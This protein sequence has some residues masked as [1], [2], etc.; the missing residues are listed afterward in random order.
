MRA[1]DLAANTDLTA[2]TG[3]I[4]VDTIAPESTIDTGPSGLIAD[5]TP[6]FEFSSNDGGATFECRFDTGSFA[7][8]SDLGA[9]T[10][11]ADLPDGPHTFEVRAKDPATNADP[12]PAARSITVDTMPPAVTIT[13][14]PSGVSGQTQASFA[15]GADEPGVSFECKLDGGAFEACTSPETVTGLS[16]DDHTFELK[17]TDAVGHPSAASVTRTW[18]V[19]LESTTETTAGSVDPGGSVTTDPADTGPTTE[20][21][22]TA[23][24]TL[25]DGGDVEV[26]TGAPTT[27]PP[28][29][30]AVL[31]QQFDITAPDGSI[32]EPLV[33]TFRLDASAI[34]AGTPISLL[35]VTRDAQPA[36][37]CTGLMGT[38]IPDPCVAGRTLLPDGDVLLTVRSTHA[39]IWNVAKRPTPT[40]TPTPPVTPTKKKCKKGQK[41]KKGKCVKKGKKRKEEVASGGV[42]ALV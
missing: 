25:P 34:P 33:L 23:S 32:A 31:G 35:T 36:N 40:V 10:P 12:T 9:H 30:F 28:T 20:R 24:I 1:R 17:G 5:A 13:A 3:S 27:T 16:E 37:D 21:P 11:A 42:T 14:G 41:L 18:E 22:V 39:S 2:A 19:D 8:C 7:S 29:G 26:T 15:F 6:T 38:A 4:T